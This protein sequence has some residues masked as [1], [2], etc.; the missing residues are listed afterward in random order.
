MRDPIFRAT[1]SAY[2]IN[3][4]PIKMKRSFRSILWMIIGKREAKRHASQ[5]W[6][7]RLCDQSACDLP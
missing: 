3:V 1:F 6:L 7:T 4:L 5:S 2:P